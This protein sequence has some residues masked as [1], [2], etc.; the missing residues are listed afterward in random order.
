M[1]APSC[2]S[3]QVPR[4][5]TLVITR[6]R[7]PTLPASVC[8]SP[9]PLCTCSSR[10]LTSLNDSPR[11]CSS[12]ACSFSSTV[13]RISSSRAA[14]S[15][16]MVARRSL[17]VPRSCSAW[18][19]LDCASPPSCCWMSFLRESS[20]LRVVCASASK[21]SC[22]WA[23]KR[24][25][26]SPW[27]SRAWALSAARR[28]VSRPSSMR[29]AASASP[30]SRRAAC[31]SS[32][33]W[34]RWAC[35]CCDTRSSPPSL[36]ATAICVAWAPRSSCCSR[37]SSICSACSNCCGAT[38]SSRCAERLHSSQITAACPNSSTAHAAHHT[39][40]IWVKILLQLHAAG[41]G[42][43]L[44]SRDCR[45]TALRPWRA[46]LRPPPRAG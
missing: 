44:P 27:A 10:S 6:L 39:P 13:R 43:G 4:V 15:D 41:S 46:R 36:L 30:C 25:V 16:W 28:T 26:L 29:K 33:A 11:R 37:T 40:D 3:P 18:T 8:I 35:S 42:Q 22:T 1:M 21:R 14:L 7:S 32:W 31:A 20:V 12:V 45:N 19:W 9:R 23:L 24:C 2:S 5:F 34:A 17:S 38:P